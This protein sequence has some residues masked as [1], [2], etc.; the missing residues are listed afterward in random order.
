MRIGFAAQNP[1]SDYWLI[2]NHGAQQRANELGIE[3][4]T[5]PSLTI[6]QQIATL[7]TFISERVDVILLGPMAAVGLA[8]TVEQARLAHIPVIVLAAQLSDCPCT[9]TIRSNHIYG[10]ELAAAHMVGQIGGAGPVAHLVGPS[11]LQ[12]NIDRAAGVHNILRQHPDVRLVYERESPD[13]APASAAVIMR[14]ALER[15]PDIRGV[16]AATDTLA[17][18]ATEAIAAAGK[19]GQIVIT[20]FDAAPEAL[21]AIHKGT[22][23]AT[24]RQS[25]LGIGR[26][27]VEMAWRIAHGEAVPPLIFSEIMLISQANLLEAT[28][29]TVF[30]M[31]GILRSAVERGIALAE[32]R[33][34]IIRTRD[35][36][37]RMQESALRELSTPLIP[38]S[39]SVMVMPLIGT[40]DALRAQQIMETLLAG[41]SARGASLVI[42]DITGVPVVDT[43][44]ANGLVEAAHAAQL[45]GARVVLTGIRPEVAQMLV[46]LGVD[47]RGIV[48]HST[49]QSGIGYALRTR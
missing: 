1:T 8:V 7:Q 21:L 23:S 47:M 5:A 36:V 11:V 18:G 31:P 45:L 30:I 20:G 43:H 19:T 15:H 42:L 40:I 4:T 28:L 29:D 41:I 49:L 13:W 44:V 37:I 16:C 25:P 26:T 35:A 6:E 22:M 12:D 32:A 34:E 24:I 27:G 10:A 39:D 46:S 17:L 48:T 33:D 38:I 3:L 14:E 2:V 9:C